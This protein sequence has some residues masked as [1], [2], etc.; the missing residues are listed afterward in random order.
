VR[1]FST[2]VKKFGIVGAGQMGTGI[3][4]VASDVGKFQT[5]IVDVDNKRTEESK[6]FIVNLLNKDVQKNKVLL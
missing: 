5:I 3:A 6:K 1:F 4:K 2:S